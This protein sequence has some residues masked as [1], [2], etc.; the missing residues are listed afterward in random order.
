MTR[1]LMLLLLLAFP[2]I[3]CSGAVSD[4]DDTTSDDDDDVF[5]DDDD[6]DSVSDDDDSSSD[7]DD[8]SSDDDDSGSDDDDSA[9]PPDYVYGLV[10]DPEAGFTGISGVTLQAVDDNT[11]TSVTDKEGAYQFEVVPGNFAIEAVMEGRYSVVATGDLETLVNV[12]SEELADAV[13]PMFTPT[14]LSNMTQPLLGVSP[15]ASDG[16]VWVRVMDTSGKPATGAS[17]G[18]DVTNSGALLL[19]GSGPSI[20]SE[21]VAGG[22]MIFF[23]NVAPGTASI[24]VSPPAGQ[25]CAGPSTTPVYAEKASIVLYVCE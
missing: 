21:L 20:G 14:S 11:S 9:E 7:D 16:M 23:V 19:S 25:T 22:M 17:V 4:D 12:R 6:D 10:V 15:Q 1:Y 8:S 24:V 13:H 18:I 3:G 5:S 2:L